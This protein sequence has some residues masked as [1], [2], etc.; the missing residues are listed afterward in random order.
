M[1]AA[2]ESYERQGTYALW[3][4]FEASRIHNESGRGGLA[5]WVSEAETD[6]ERGLRKNAAFVH[7]YGN[8]PGGL[9]D[10]VVVEEPLIGYIVVRRFDCEGTEQGEDP[11][12]VYLDRAP[13]EAAARKLNSRT[14]EISGEVW[15][16]E[17]PPIY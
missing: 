1:S 9:A 5:V 2:Q 15:E 14:Y 11:S 8:G 4:Y 13:A 10:L 7:F 17:L 3:L 16:I 12:K 6:E